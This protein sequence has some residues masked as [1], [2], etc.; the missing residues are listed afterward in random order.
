MRQRPQTGCILRVCRIPEVKEMRARVC[1]AAV[2]ARYGFP[3]FFACKGGRRHLAPDRRMTNVPIGV[4]TFH[5][6][7]LWEPW[8]S[9]PAG[10]AVLV[11]G[12]IVVCPPMLVT[13]LMHRWMKGRA[14]GVWT[15]SGFYLG[16]LDS[17]VL[18]T[19]MYQGW[20]KPGVSTLYPSLVFAVLMLSSV[21]VHCCR[22]RTSLGRR[23][24]HI[25]LTRYGMMLLFP[26]WNP[27]S[28][29][30]G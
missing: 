25:W 30:P 22:F 7:H 2:R 8:N 29:W 12:G 24:C 28:A 16:S 11:I 23:A 10:W 26:R 19:A 5:I 27:L 17:A 4:G 3:T 18:V 20:P 21:V 14:H 9:V 13:W 1:W 15:S 6:D